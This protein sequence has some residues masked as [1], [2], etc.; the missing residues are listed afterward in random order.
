MQNMQIYVSNT[1]Y[2]RRPNQSK[3]IKLNHAII[4]RKT[5]STVIMLLYFLT[6]VV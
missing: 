2:K 3:K 5:I 4:L 1:R 6:P